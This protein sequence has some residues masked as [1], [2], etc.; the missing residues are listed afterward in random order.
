[1]PHRRR[2]A[3]IAVV[4]ILCAAWILS[5]EAHHDPCHRHRSCPSERGAVTNGRIINT[6]WP[7]SRV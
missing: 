7:A 5:V 3:A 4:F 1:M 6:A 2:S